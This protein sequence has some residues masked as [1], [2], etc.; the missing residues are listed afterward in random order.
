VNVL[1]PRLRTTIWTLLRA[2]NSQ[3]EIERRTGI[4]RHTIQ[5][6]AKRFD[7]QAGSPAEANCPNPPTDFDTGGDLGTGW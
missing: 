6:W 1:K 5:A 2:G 4:S 7:V 3:R